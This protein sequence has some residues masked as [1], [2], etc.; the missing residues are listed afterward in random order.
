VVKERSSFPQTRP[1][2]WEKETGYCAS[3][4]KKKDIKEWEKNK[5]M[6]GG[7]TKTFQRKKTLPH[8]V[9]KG[10]VFIP[11]AREKNFNRQS[12]VCLF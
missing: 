1:T 4:R 5:T 3:K 12:W 7:T 6:P 8:A 10:K 2:W 11:K 9:K